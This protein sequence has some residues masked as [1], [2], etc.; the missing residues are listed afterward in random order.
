ML[1]LTRTG[2]LTVGSPMGGRLGERLGERGASLVGC[3]V[4]TLGLG[5]AAW[6]TWE[7]SV[8]LFVMGLIGQGLG[9]G[10][11]QP[12]ITAAISRS[13]DESDL[14]IA[15]ASNRLFGQGG[16]AFGI[17]I[18]TLVYAGVNTPQAFATTF[19]VATGLSAISVITALWI[20]ASKL[21]LHADEEAPIAPAT[22]R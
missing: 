19:L 10:W 21:E 16:A 18:L 8:F 4:M 2:A 7:Q 13:V 14:G 1:I 20:G 12:S 17:T 3:G 5:L 6:G 15:A 11:S 22:G 9:H